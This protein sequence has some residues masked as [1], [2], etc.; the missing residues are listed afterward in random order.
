MRFIVR[1]RIFS[2][3]TVSPS[4]DELGNDHFVVKGRVFTLGNKLGSM[5]WPDRNCT[6]EQKILR[7]LPEYNIYQ[8]GQPIAKVKKEFTFLK[9][10]FNIT[11]TLGN[12]TIHGNFLGMNFSILKMAVTQPRYPN[13]G[14]HFPTP[15]V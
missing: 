7:F 11:S 14:S 6:I 5:T 8:Y 10:R 15:M 2:L 4:S 12:F 3:G 9:P 13:A 1:Q